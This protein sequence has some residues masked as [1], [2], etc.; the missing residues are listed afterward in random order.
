MKI[1]DVLNHFIKTQTPLAEVKTYSSKPG[2]YAIFLIEKEFPLNGFKLPENKII[3]IGKTEKSQ[4]S[5]DANT[6]FKSGK[7]GSSTLRRTIAALLSQTQKITPLIRT[8]ADVEKQR[9][10]HFKLDESS[11]EI[12]S[13]WMNDN[14]AVAFFEYPETKEKINQLETVLKTTTVWVQT[15]AQK[16]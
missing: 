3:Y 16:Y 15:L 11:E 8:M 6:H 9:I 5:R 13:N 1:N 2:I 14:L 7:T 4:L 12:V 10:T